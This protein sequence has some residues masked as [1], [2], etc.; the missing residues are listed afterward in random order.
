MLNIFWEKNK[1]FAQFESQ[2]CIKQEEAQSLDSI[3]NQAEIELI[4][5]FSVTSKYFPSRLPC[6]SKTREKNSRGFDFTTVIRNHVQTV[7]KHKIDIEG[8][9]LLQQRRITRA[10]LMDDEI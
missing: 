1:K 6:R 2:F 3:D 10:V 9:K 8:G 7:I 5:S 4:M